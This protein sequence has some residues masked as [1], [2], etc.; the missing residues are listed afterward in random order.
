MADVIKVLGQAKNIVAEAAL[1][2]VPNLT[3][4]TCSTLV[5][6]NRTSGALTFRVGVRKSGEGADDEQYLFY[7]TSLAANSTLAAT[8][9]ITLDQDDA[10]RVDSS[11]TGLSFNLFG[12]ETT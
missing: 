12:V 5:V 1:Y 8:I 3:Q 4:A 7:D 9:G 6:C 10:V 11:A 2:T